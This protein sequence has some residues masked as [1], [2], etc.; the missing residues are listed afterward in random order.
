LNILEKYFSPEEA[1]A[2]LETA[3]NW[4]RYAELFT[5]QDDRGM[6]RLEETD[7]AET[8]EKKG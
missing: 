1:E 2:Q 7:A 8:S 6:F 3:I 5:F 4:G